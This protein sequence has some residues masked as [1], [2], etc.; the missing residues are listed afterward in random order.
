VIPNLLVI[1]PADADETALAWTLALQRQ[2]GPTA[3]ILTRQNLPV[4]H[5]DQR[6]T[7]V[8][9]QRGGYIVQEADHDEPEFVLIATG[10]EVALAA[11]VRTTLQTE[12][13]FTRLVSLPADRLFLQ[14]PAAVRQQI[15]GG[16]SAK[17]VVLEAGVPDLW[18]RIVGS[19][20]L[21]IGQERFGESAPAPEL[22]RHFGFTAESVLAK[23]KE[24]G[25]I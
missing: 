7:L 22:A 6:L 5:R 10:S 19:D 14:Q 9:M 24:Q 12:G 21:V 17:R 16:A 13:H 25:W 11:K 23:I 3:L 4:L 1:R 20:A 8:K 18:P 15:L 2:D